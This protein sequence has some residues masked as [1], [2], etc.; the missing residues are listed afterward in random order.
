[1]TAPNLNP[2]G[3][4][5]DPPSA[6]AVALCLIAR[7][8]GDSKAHPRP[9]AWEEWSRADLAA[10][11]DTFHRQAEWSDRGGWRDIGVERF[12]TLTAQDQR[13]L[14]VAAQYAEVP[15]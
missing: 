5:L 14:V 4:V 3:L 12:R 8:D 7:I 15:V 9:C 13:R 6:V 10:M 11:L 1:M 2:N